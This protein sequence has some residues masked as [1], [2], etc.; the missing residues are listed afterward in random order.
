MVKV[1]FSFLFAMF[2]ICD[3]A[4]SRPPNAFNNFFDNVKPKH[5]LDIV[6]DSELGKTCTIDTVETYDG[7]RGH[8]KIYAMCKGANGIPLYAYKEY[9]AEGDLDKLCNVDGRIRS[10]EYCTV[11]YSELGKNCDI[12]K[13][14]T[15]HGHTQHYRIYASCKNEKG[16]Y[17]HAFKK[18]VHKDELGFLCNVDGEIKKLGEEGCKVPKN[19][20]TGLC[21]ENNIIRSEEYCTVKYSRLGRNC[22]IKKVHTYHDHTQHYRVYA[23]CKN[24]KG[25]LVDAFIE[26]V[27][28]DVLGNLCNV[29]GVIIKPGE[30]G[31]K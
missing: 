23:D 6:K 30:E 16:D 22:N 19:D 7:H 26:H 2:L 3:F 27:Y 21:S 17:V 20:W 14:E 1:F 5:M 15:Y 4:Y 9:V 13:A 18:Y 29:D 25:K 8:Y 28:K 12:S 24:K 31:C 11:K 10:A